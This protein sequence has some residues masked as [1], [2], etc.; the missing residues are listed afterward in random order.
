MTSRGY[1]SQR[2]DVVTYQE[3]SQIESTNYHSHIDT[4][5]LKSKQMVIDYRVRVYRDMISKATGSDLGAQ[6]H[7]CI[8]KNTTR[9]RTDPTEWQ[10]MMDKV[11]DHLS[12][13]NII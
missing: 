11:L 10:S 8:W 9:I 3:R 13:V 6:H 5:D 12:K 7:R 4:V 2:I 1:K